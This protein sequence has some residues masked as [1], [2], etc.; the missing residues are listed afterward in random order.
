ME[1]NLLRVEFAAFLTYI[2]NRIFACFWLYIPSL[3][4]PRKDRN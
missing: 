3:L 1:D 4:R 2:R